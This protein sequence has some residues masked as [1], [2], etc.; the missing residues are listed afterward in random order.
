MSIFSLS[1]RRKRSLPWLKEMIE[2]NVH[3][4]LL[5]Q[6]RRDLIFDFSLCH[7]DLAR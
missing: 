6:L 3:I 4:L 5:P 2:H 1:R 7:L